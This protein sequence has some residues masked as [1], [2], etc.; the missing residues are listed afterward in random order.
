MLCI[1][2][3]TQNNSQGNSKVG[4]AN[5]C[6]SNFSPPFK[7]DKLGQSLR[8]TR[9]NVWDWVFKQG[10]MSDSITSNSLKQFLWYFSPKWWKS[11]EI[12]CF[13]QLSDL[14]GCI[15]LIF[16]RKELQDLNPVWNQ[17]RITF[18]TPRTEVIV[19]M[20]LHRT[21]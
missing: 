18:E 3:E 15:W 8:Q 11:Y 20:T 14:L 2:T 6:P 17:N 5:F 1:K 4:D 13:Y 10:L 19:E 9:A 12:S 7:L 16:R 21:V